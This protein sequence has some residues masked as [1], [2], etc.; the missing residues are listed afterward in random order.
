M[1]DN[2]VERQGQILM[3]KQKTELLTDAEKDIVFSYWKIV[4][5]RQETKMEEAM[6]AKEIRKLKEELKATEAEEE[7]T[8]ASLAALEA[9][10][11][12]KEAEAKRQREAKEEKQRP[13]LEG[14]VQSATNL[15]K[16][17]Y[18][19]LEMV[20]KKV[21]H[22]RDVNRSYVDFSLEKY[23]LAQQKTKLG[24]RKMEQEAALS[25]KQKKSRK[26]NLG[27][28]GKRLAKINKALG[29]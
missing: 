5:E 19:R 3:E 26:K 8:A 7:S 21:D 12:A 16:D 1:D 27:K 18:D 15:M 25:R 9:E 20:E 14:F 28:K 2:D 6:E 10:F 23:S 11:Q 22:Q 4:V 29:L 17:V 13:L 24:K